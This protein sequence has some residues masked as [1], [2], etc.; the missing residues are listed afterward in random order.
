LAQLCL[1][2]SRQQATTEQEDDKPQ[3]SGLLPHSTRSKR[4]SFGENVK[5]SFF[6]NYMVG[7]KFSVQTWLASAPKEKEKLLEQQ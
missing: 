3:D 6:N 5:N 2:W 1:V 4:I 7:Q